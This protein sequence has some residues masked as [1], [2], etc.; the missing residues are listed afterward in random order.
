MRHYC[1]RWQP[2]GIFTVDAVAV[3]MGA[4]SVRFAHGRLIDGRIELEVIKQ[5][6]N[7][8]LGRCWDTSLLTAFCRSALDFA[9]SKNAS[10]GIDSW[11]VD[12]GFLDSH[13]DL[14]CG[15]VM[16]RDPSHLHQYDKFS[17]FRKR[18]FELTGIAHQPFNTLY[19]LAARLEEDSTLPMRA[20]WYLMPDLMNY[21]L[22]GKRSHEQTQ[23][24]TTQL[25]GLDGTWCREAFELVGWPVPDQEPCPCGGIVEVVEKVPVVSVASH[26]TGS[27][28]LGVGELRP[29][30]AYLNVGTWALLG[31]VLE[32]PCASSAAEE[33]GWTNEW[34]FGGAIRFL[35]N[36]PGFYVVNRLHRELGVNTSVGEWLQSRNTAFRGR[37]N[38]QDTSLYNP[39]SMPMACNAIVSVVPTS[40]EDWAQAALASL[41]ECIASDVPKLASTTGRT[42]DRIRVVGGGSRS[43]AFCQALADETSV[44]VVSGPVEATVLGNLAL[45]FVATGQI[46]P[47]NLSR[48][49]SNSVKTVTYQ[50]EGA[51]SASI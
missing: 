48:T 10:L 16:Y 38:V 41:V 51:P 23:S 15:P 30:D 13:G 7:E 47:E 31:N 2:G 46:R 1:G 44:D 18:L 22:T 45:Q 39:E 19:Q 32:R 3:D 33:G 43:V 25:M 40:L 49:V 14:V 29:N 24:S 37:F 4:T 12:H 42:I 36:I 11:G 34:G 17:F 35:K 28:V 6:P 20:Q 27:A 50:P 5:T 9:A 26:D 21:F 8:P